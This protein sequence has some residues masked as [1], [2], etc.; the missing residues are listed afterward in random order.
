MI[1]RG[2]AGFVAI[3]LILGIGTLTPAA[4][5]P[6]HDA[7][8]TIEGEM[9]VLCV[10]RYDGHKAETVYAV[11]DTKTG[12]LHKLR[13]EK[14]PD[15]APLTGDKVTIRGKKRNDEIVL[16]ADGST[17]VQTV[18][19]AAQ[20]AGERRAVVLLVNF[21][22][23]TVPCSVSAIQNIVSPDPN[24]G[25]ANPNVSDY[26]Y[27][28]SYE[29]VFLNFD[30]QQDGYADI[31]GPFTIDVYSTDPCPNYTT[32][33][34]DWAA[35]ADAAATA[36]GVPLSQYQ[37]IVYV[38]PTGH[39]CGFYALGNIG[40]GTQCRTWMSG[41][42]HADAFAHELGH[43]L[44]MHHAATDT[45]NDGVQE[46]EYGDFSCIMGYGGV[47]YRHPNAPHKDHLGWFD[48]FPGASTTVTSS[49]RY[50]LAPL[51]QDPAALGMAQALKI[52]IPARGEYYYLS[53][54][55]KDGYD[56]NFWNTTYPDK[57]NIHRARPTA[58]NKSYFVRALAAGQSFSDASLGV[59]VTNV[60]QDIDPV[61]GYVAVQIDYACVAKAPGVTV[62]PTGQAT[63]GIAVTYTVSVSNQ[64]AGGC[65]SATFSVAAAV[66]SGWTSSVSPASLELDAGAS[67]TFAWTVT[68]SA[69]AA[70]GSYA[71]SATVRDVTGAHADVVRNVSCVV[72]KT[73]PAPVSLSASIERKTTVALAWTTAT[74]PVMVYR[75]YRND[76]SGFLLLASTSSTS[77]YDSS[78]SAGATASYYVVAVDRVG[79][80]SAPSNEAAVS[81]EGKTNSGG[82]KG[83]G[84]KK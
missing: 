68:P 15:R 42:G 10:D 83:G 35:K 69:H 54:R 22:D 6:L 58:G 13:Y 29:Q 46:D 23:K 14:L 73:P 50:Y 52:Y 17:N 12:K 76:G 8:V 78:L 64:D 82:A 75:V 30:V 20:V 33:V 3:A 38:L 79:N 84:P 18:E 70:D 66:P 57:L 47:G 80:A 59:T 25:Y 62:A 37:H 71:L 31:F 2:R 56:Q 36:A 51:A 74:E 67:G 45:N 53:Y 41:C 34:Y 9:Q 7:E 1:D 19:A 40:C 60:G 48:A 27:E 21:L 49:G 44:G 16:E 72:D 11:I 55:V 65:G 4:G 26:F 43:N 61:M 32:A 24:R 63:S 81:L 39:S 28:A 77:Y 5:L